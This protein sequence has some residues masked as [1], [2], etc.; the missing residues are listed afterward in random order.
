MVD[1]VASTG[2]DRISKILCGDKIIR[3]S[4]K[5]PPIGYSDANAVRV[6]LESFLAENGADHVERFG[7][8]LIAPID[9]GFLAIK[10]CV[11]YGDDERLLFEA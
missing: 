7:R 10:L 1:K 6:D 8:T 9:E 11:D 2:F 4:Q 3:L 5:M